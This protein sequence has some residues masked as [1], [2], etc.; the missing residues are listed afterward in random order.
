MI[1]KEIQDRGY[2]V[3]DDLFDDIFINELD[4]ITNGNNG[5]IKWGLNNYANRSGYPYGT[6]GTHQFWGNTLFNRK[7]ED[8]IINECPD[9]IYS[10]LKFIL[11]DV[12]R[13]DLRLDMIQMNGQSLGQE[14]TTH[15]DDAVSKYTLMYFVNSKWEK[16]WGGS[17]EFMG[18]DNGKL[19]TREN[20]NFIPGR[21]ILFDGSIPHRAKAPLVPYV[22]RKTI[23]F[24]LN[25]R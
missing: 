24:R 23:V 16:T 3:W 2:I 22:V 1:L 15:T 4:F 25:D 19:I 13:T 9:K 11:Q 7:S 21:V 14:G 20:I 17:L 6:K 8:E 10:M 12:I 18:E 5:Q